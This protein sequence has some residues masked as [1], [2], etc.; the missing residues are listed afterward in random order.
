MNGLESE[1]TNN[2]TIAI[3]NEDNKLELLGINNKENVV[4][5]RLGRISRSYN[6]AKHFLETT[7]YQ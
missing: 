4:H 3:K 1:V 2:S 7:Y 6:F 5:T